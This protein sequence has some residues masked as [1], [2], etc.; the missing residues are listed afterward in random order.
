MAYTQQQTVF[1][2]SMLSNL[3]ISQTGTVDYLEQYLAE[4]IDA[5]LKAQQGDIGVWT[6][7]WGPAVYQ[8]PRST[9]TDNVM[10]VARS[11]A[12]PSQYVVCV[13]G[14]NFNSVFDILIEDLFVGQQVPWFYGNPP[15]GAA[16]AAGTFIGLS[17]L[18]ILT[19]GAAMPGAGQGVKDFLKAQASQAIQVITSGHSLGGA[20]S[21]CL[22]LWLLDTQR[23]WDPQSRATITSEP[24]AG[25]T[26]GNA[27]FAQYYDG[28]LGA[29]TT[30][31][32]NS[33]DI[34]PH[35]WND[36]DL[37]AL[38]NLYNPPI[39]PD[40]IVNGLV[41][42]ARQ[43]AKNG[44]YTQIETGLQLDGT[45]NTTIVDPKRLAFENYLVQAGYQHIDAYFDLLHVTIGSTAMVVLR[46]GL[47]SP[48]ALRVAPALRAR[49]ERRGAIAAGAK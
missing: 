38:P 31:I 42:A 30:N 9:V 26:A 19:P 5:H 41:A 16:I 13:A 24:S 20:L 11:N 6:R 4:H 36:T 35:A 18:Q 32:H 33:L 37:A 15:S 1:F 17:V 39:V 7:V 22:A 25:P 14:T 27:T 12:T 49:L 2:L 29:V 34:V 28:R 48:A 23:T 43:L 44:S 45:V 21:P 10:Y 46:E 40:A 3:A 47:G 8:A